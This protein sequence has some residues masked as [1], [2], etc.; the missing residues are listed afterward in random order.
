MEQALAKAAREREKAELER[1]KR[2]K[3]ET[4]RQTSITNLVK[5]LA[6]SGNNEQSIVSELV[7]VFGLPLSQAE[8]YYRQT[9]N[10]A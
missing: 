10:P 9:I 7:T 3:A 1:R 2:E 8:N 4:E 6:N 5:L